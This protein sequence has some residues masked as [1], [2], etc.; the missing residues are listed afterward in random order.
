MVW[1]PFTEVKS[2]EIGVEAGRLETHGLSHTHEPIV[3][4]AWPEAEDYDSSVHGRRNQ[5]TRG[6]LFYIWEC[7]FTARNPRP[8]VGNKSVAKIKE[9]LLP[10][11]F[12][13]VFFFTLLKLKKFLKQKSLQKTKTNPHTIC[14]KE[15]KQTKQKPRFFGLCMLIEVKGLKQKSVIESN[16][17]RSLVGHA[18][19]GE[20]TYVFFSQ[21]YTNRADNVLENRER[22]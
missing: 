19:R 15:P 11:S 10:S 14:C 8:F 9:N 4:G 20:Q 6:L 18:N 17:R 1:I 5:T 12:E 13:I 21:T 7:L 22:D 3:T 16:P 2:F